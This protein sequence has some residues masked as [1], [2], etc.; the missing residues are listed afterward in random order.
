MAVGGPPGAVRLAGVIPTT[1]PGALPSSDAVKTN[2]DRARQLL[3]EANAGDLKGQLSFSTGHVFYGVQFGIV[4]EKVQADLAKVGIQ[5]TLDGL[6]SG[7]ALQKYRDAKDQLGIWAWA[8]DY[9]DVSDYLVFAP[10]RTVGKRA[11]WMPDASP[12]AQAL[13]QLAT[14]AETEVDTPKRVALYQQFNRRVA[15]I[16][17]FAP[18]FQPVAPYAFRS[19]IRGVVLASTWFVDYTTV[20]KG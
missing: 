14:R 15:E 4:A 19:S 11:G 1:L 13:A 16:G 5:L 17:P 6:P 7:I 2:L 10:G 12:E 9:P 18:M 8:A 3:K 20:R